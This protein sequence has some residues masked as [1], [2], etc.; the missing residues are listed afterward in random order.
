MAATTECPIPIVDF[1][2][3]NAATAEQ[4]KDIVQ[5]I[6]DACRDIGFFMIKNHGV[7]QHVI[8]DMMSKTKDFFD[9]PVDAK[10]AYTSQDEEKYPYGSFDSFQAA[11]LLPL[12]FRLAQGMLAF[13]RRLF[14]RAWRKRPR[15]VQHPALQQT[16]SPQN[17]E[18]KS[19]LLTS[20]SACQWGLI[21]L[22]VA[23]LLRSFLHSPTALP[24]RGWATTRFVQRSVTMQHNSHQLHLQA[25]EN[26]A[27]DLLEAFALA[28]EQD[29]DW[30]KDKTDK[31]RCA[32]RALN[33]PD[34]ETAPAAGQL[35]ASP[36]T[37][38]GTLTILMPDDAPGGLQ[39]KGKD[40]S[41]LP[42]PYMPGH[43]VINI[44][45]LMQR[46]TNDQWV[47]TIHRVVP[48]TQAEV[49]SRDSCRRQSVAFF[50][51]VNADVLVEAIPSTVGTYTHPAR[52]PLP[53]YT[54]NCALQTRRTQPST[55]PSLRL[56]T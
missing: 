27:G 25:M 49:D 13:S 30:F 46:W 16:S 45:D 51:N 3:W 38:Y 55:Q 11:L 22:P 48:P 10:E 7:D 47:S 19:R 14:A 32:L 53:L 37:D 23:C 42:V 24:M 52:A 34:L 5:A 17:K 35:R 4:K 21:T 44:G 18:A 31:H 50:H 12:Y 2:Q 15:R 9:L 29:A 6:G 20:R 36:H 56:S 26:L 43:Y 54:T 39:V 41:W 33:Y 1:K 8:D 28:L 40:G